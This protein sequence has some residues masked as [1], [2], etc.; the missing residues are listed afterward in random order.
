MQSQELEW[1]WDLWK[2]ES[3]RGSDCGVVVML[4]GSLLAEEAASGML[5]KEHSPACT[6]GKWGS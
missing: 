4:G 1:L 6:G 2:E 5:A 3:R